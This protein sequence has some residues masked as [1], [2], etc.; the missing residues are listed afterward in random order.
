VH[1][2]GLLTIAPNAEMAEL[3]DRMLPVILARQDW[4]IWLGE[5][6]ALPDT[7]GTQHGFPQ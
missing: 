2:Y 4:P 1:T 5:A 7:R 3:H 6:D